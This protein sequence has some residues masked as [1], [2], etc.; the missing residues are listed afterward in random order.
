MSV[1]E[2]CEK[3]FEDGDKA[4]SGLDFCCSECMDDICE[5]CY[6]AISPLTSEVFFGRCVRCKDE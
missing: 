6:S 2:Y 5:I 4:I 3:E 1:C